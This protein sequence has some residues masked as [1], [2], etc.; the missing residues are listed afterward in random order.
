MIP[1]VL[2]TVYL[3]MLWSTPPLSTV[4]AFPTSKPHRLLVVKQ[5]QHR[6]LLPTSTT[7]L[8]SSSFSS[9]NHENNKNDSKSTSSSNIK[10]GGAEDN[11][12]S[13]YSEV[14]WITEV[15]VQYKLTT[16]L[17]YDPIKDRYVEDTQ[18][19]YQLQQQ[20]GQEGG[21]QTNSFMNSFIRPMLSSAFIPEG[22]LPSYYN[23]MR[24]RVAQRFVNANLHVIGTQSLLLALGMKSSS[25]RS[26][27]VSAAL[28]WVLKDALG[29][30]ARL[31]WA[32]KMSRKFDSDAKRWRFR[33]SI[34]FAYGNFL[35]I[36][37]Y[38]NPQLF[39]LWATLANAAKQ[40]A[41]LTSS[42][43]R[44]ALYNSFRDGTRENIGDITAKGEAQIAIVDLCGIASGVCLSRVIGTGI[45]NVLLAYAG[46]Q[47]LEIFCM[48]FELKAVQ[49]R[50][51]NFERLALV[52]KNYVN[53][54]SS[55][56]ESSTNNINGKNKVVVIPTP[57]EMSQS[58]RIFLPPKHL[59]RRGIAFGSLGRAKLSPNELDRLMSIFATERFLLVVGPNVKQ[60]SALPRR[61]KSISEQ[62]HIVLHEEASNADIVKSTM[63]LMIL[64]EKLIR[65]EKTLRLHDNTD[66]RS[67]IIIRSSQCWDI[68]EESK[69]ECNVL[70]PSFLRELSSQ[71]WA[72]PS[73][74]M[75]GRVHKRAHWP[76]RTTPTPT[77]NVDKEKNK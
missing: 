60:T 28:N 76:L 19:K 25:S 22:V 34:V 39:L 8:Q 44:T 63:A 17:Q 15:D 46:L 52:I 43:T 72:P 9:S 51:L 74:F 70:F 54:H 29:K 24:W 71:S 33:A 68:L 3:T 55:P 57:E 48:Y 47:V 14:P 59:S 2:V 20:Q 42:S 31:I 35:E 7:L 75:F 64:R 65:F 50:V 38:I 61:N 11:K 49:F 21:R 26:L 41:M 73:R 16:P 53:A 32:S 37:T 40:I 62:C 12:D 58:E 23:F 18:R 56:K 45:K 67:Q 69:V 36:V 4:I 1:F 66:E 27:G 6:L 30:M 5:Q 13:S 77:R 10:V